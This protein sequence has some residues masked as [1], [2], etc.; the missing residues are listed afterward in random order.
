[1]KLDRLRAEVGGW[2]TQN[3][4]DQPASYALLGATEEVG[5]LS[6]AYLRTYMTEAHSPG[7]QDRIRLALE[8]Q[9]SVGRLNHSILKRTQGIRLDEPGVGE[10]AEKS[11]IN[12]IKRNLADIEAAPHQ[13]GREIKLD[14]V[15]DPSL[16]MKDAVADTVIYLA[17]FAH[18]SGIDLDQTVE[19][20]WREIVSEREWDSDLGDSDAA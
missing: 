13:P 15:P 16:E 6:E 11:A 8:L 20:T 5:E 9:A 1:M 7:V 17:D 12:R 3:F 14:A 2:A 4:G 10:A 18:R 19:E